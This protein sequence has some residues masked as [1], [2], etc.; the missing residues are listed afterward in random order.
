MREVEGRCTHEGDVMDHDPESC[1]ICLRSD[2][3]KFDPT[4]GF[5]FVPHDSEAAFP[6]FR[7]YPIVADN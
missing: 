4:S 3:F 1:T 2:R 6:L 5:H 7:L